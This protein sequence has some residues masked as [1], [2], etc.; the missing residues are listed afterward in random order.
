MLPSEILGVNNYSRDHVK[1][2]VIPR[3]IRFFPDEVEKAM[4]L[5]EAMNKRREDGDLPFGV[6][7]VNHEGL[8]GLDCKGV[9]FHFL[10]AIGVIVPTILRNSPPPSSFNFVDIGRAWQ[11]LNIWRAKPVQDEDD[12]PCN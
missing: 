9:S 10:S 7:P 5:L 3:F 1:N 8:K 4:K 11:I 6:I 12:A 2:R